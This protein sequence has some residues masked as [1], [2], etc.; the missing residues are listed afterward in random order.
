MILSIK[1]SV[2]LFPFVCLTFIQHR[3]NAKQNYE[4]GTEWSA[5]AEFHNVTYNLKR[6][7]I[8]IKS[9]CFGSIYEES[10][11][12]TPNETCKWIVEFSIGYE[13]GHPENSGMSLALKLDDGGKAGNAVAKFKATLLDDFGREVRSREE[14]QELRVGKDE[15]LWE[16]FIKPD[17]VL[18]NPFV[19]KDPF[20]ISLE[21]SYYYRCSNFTSRDQQNTISPD[22]NTTKCLPS[23]NIGSLLENE[24][25][26]DVVLL[27]K[28]KNY[29]AHGAV[30]AAS[31]EV[32]ASMFK[33][34]E[35]G[36]KKHEKNRIDVTDIDADV[37]NEVLRYIYTGKCQI[38][39]KLAERLYAAADAYKL[40]KLKTIVLESM[41]DALSQAAFEKRFHLRKNRKLPGRSSADPLG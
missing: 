5:A 7:R 1:K 22:P 4:T 2:L 13:Y 26:T 19:T 17:D 37:M 27:A 35:H 39:A 15:I 8:D 24:D 38:S 34:I 29:S 31:S 25:F 36:D 3:S 41:A 18:R 40:D 11:S 33:N 21:I 23:D 9:R 6:D 16:N 30:L 12:M 32:F 14:L 10:T 20:T 28:G